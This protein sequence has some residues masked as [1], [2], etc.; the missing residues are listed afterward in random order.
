MRSLVFCDG[1]VGV[2]SARSDVL[3]KI[4]MSFCPDSLDDHW[5][6][7]YVVRGHFNFVRLAAVEELDLAQSTEPIFCP[8]NIAERARVN[9]DSGV[10][11]L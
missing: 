11:S 10:S 6:R 7:P 8:S 2:L 3:S 9:A 1:D 5:P 4:V